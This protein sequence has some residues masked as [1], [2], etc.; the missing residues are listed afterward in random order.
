M[1]SRRQFLFLMGAAPALVTLPSAARAGGAHDF[2]F[3]SI[4][5]QPLPL[6]AYE[7]KAVLLVNTASRCGFTPQYADLQD[8]WRRYREGA[9]G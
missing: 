8:L 6:G 1:P 9:G 3:T 2:G 4:E 5:G 7:G